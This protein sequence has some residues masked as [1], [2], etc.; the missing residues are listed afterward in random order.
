MS[1]HHVYFSNLSF[2]L[3]LFTVSLT[4]AL[5]EKSATYF[6]RVS[7]IGHRKESK[8]INATAKLQMLAP[9]QRVTLLII[10][11]HRISLNLAG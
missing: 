10:F 3:I 4:V 9:L 1:S 8:I 6:S 7:C 5:A 2:R 11:A